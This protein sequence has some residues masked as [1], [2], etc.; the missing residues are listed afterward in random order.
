[1]SVGVFHEYLV[2]ASWSALASLC[3]ISAALNHPAV[4]AGSFQSVDTAFPIK[5]CY[6]ET[7]AGE[8]LIAMQHKHCAAQ[9]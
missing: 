1:M 9:K 4:P 8:C 7:T 2:M 6:T 5:I 3:P